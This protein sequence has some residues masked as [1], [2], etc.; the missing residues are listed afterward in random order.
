[1]NQKS[2]LSL[3][4]ISQLNRKTILNL[5]EYVKTGQIWTGKLETEWAL[6]RYLDKGDEPCVPPSQ[7]TSNIYISLT[8]TSMHTCNN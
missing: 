5:L 2:G 1:M 4:N 7:K 8:Q 3:E 6:K